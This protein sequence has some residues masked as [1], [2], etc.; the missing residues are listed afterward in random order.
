LEELRKINV[1]N[2]FTWTDMEKENK[3]KTIFIILFIFW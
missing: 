2:N 1:F 3:S